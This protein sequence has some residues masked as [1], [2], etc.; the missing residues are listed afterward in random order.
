MCVV[1]GGRVLEHSLPFPAWALS[2]PVHTPYAFPLLTLP[3]PCRGAFCLVSILSLGLNADH[4]LTPSWW[5]WPP[6][7]ISAAMG[8]LGY[9]PPPDQQ[10]DPPDPR[11]VFSLESAV[12]RSDEGQ[13]GISDLPL[14]KKGSCPGFCNSCTLS[15]LAEPP[16]HL[17]FAHTPC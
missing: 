13:L 14:S 3:S 1:G 11:E 17:C 2:Y 9:P 10:G 4:D 15:Y 5:L 16:L 6:I 12:H 7:F 8:C